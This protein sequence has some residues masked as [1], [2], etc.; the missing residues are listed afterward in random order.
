M[1][2]GISMLCEAAFSGGNII[3]GE[4]AFSGGLGMP[5]G[6]S[7][8][9][10]TACS[11]ETACPVVAA[12]LGCSMLGGHSMPRGSSMPGFSVELFYCMLFHGNAVLPPRY[13]TPWVCCSPCTCCSLLGVLLRPALGL[14]LLNQVAI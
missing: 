9:G 4:V 3:P 11:E 2:R 6:S 1:P 8:P 12:C 14:L 13:D 7:M 10:D 5:S